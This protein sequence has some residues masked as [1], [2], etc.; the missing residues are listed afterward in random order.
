MSTSPT[1]ASAANA[2]AEAVRTLNHL[3]LGSLSPGRP[4]WEQLSD[5]YVVVADLRVLAER[6]P[7]AFDQLARV[8]EQPG[9]RFDADDGRDPVDVATTAG[10][11]LLS[12]RGLANDVARSLARAHEAISHLVVVDA[13]E[14]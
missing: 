2:A 5:V 14:E 13:D 11:A 4:D 7:Q 3:T 6:L 1:P 9:R 10:E 12:A 8:F